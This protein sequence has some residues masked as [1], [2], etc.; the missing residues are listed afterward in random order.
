[1]KLVERLVHEWAVWPMPGAICTL[2][3][4]GK[5]TLISGIIARTIISC[6]GKIDYVTQEQ[7]VEEKSKIAREEAKCESI[8]D[9]ESWRAEC[10]KQYE[11]E[12]WDKVATRLFCEYVAERKN[13]CYFNENHATQHAFK[14]ADYFIAERAKSL[15]ER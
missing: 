1:M 14:Y 11:Q 5:P 4:H 10:E 8:Q 9:E 15:K 7:W 6:G 13:S 12:L 2:D 3:E